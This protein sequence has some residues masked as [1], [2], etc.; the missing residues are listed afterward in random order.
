MHG[1][2]KDR[3]LKRCFEAVALFVKNTLTLRQ[4]LRKKALRREP[5]LLQ[6]S[7]ADAVRTVQ[8]GG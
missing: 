3:M 4:F 1:R 8:V 5:E 7:R 6:F 2:Y